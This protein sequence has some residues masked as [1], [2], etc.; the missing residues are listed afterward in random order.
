MIRYF[1]QAQYSPKRMLLGYELFLREYV[2]GQWRFPKNLRQYHAQEITSLAEQTIATLEPAARVVSI[3]L[4]QDQFVDANFIEAFIKIAHTFPERYVVVELTEYDCHV[5]R[6]DLRLATIRYSQ[7]GVYVCLDDVGS[8]ENDEAMATL[9]DDYVSE[10][11]FALQNFREEDGTVNQ[12]LSQLAA[13]GRRAKQND[14]G[15]VVEG[16]ENERNLLIVD[17]YTPDLIQGYLFAKPIL[18][19]LK[20]DVF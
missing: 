9:L 5:A 2:G 17:Q 8:G 11:K 19:P 7:G 12:L 13:W 3:N 10:Y 15:F 16:I 14:K 6:E 4:D 20:H 18:L 1:G